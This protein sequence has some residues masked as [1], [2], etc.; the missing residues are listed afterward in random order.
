MLLTWGGTTLS[1]PF[2]CLKFRARVASASPS[3]SW[4]PGAVQIASFLQRKAHPGTVDHCFCCMS[5]L[6]MD[7]G[8]RK[9]IAF[10]AKWL[11]C[12]FQYY[13]RTYAHFGRSWLEASLMLHVERSL[14]CNVLGC[15]IL[16]SIF[17]VNTFY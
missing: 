8:G 12:D 11:I 1:F 7:L 10:L 17:P 16:S 2:S 3:F 9:T 5:S 14:T 13:P 15:D 6:N 4:A